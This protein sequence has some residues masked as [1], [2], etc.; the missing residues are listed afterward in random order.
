MRRACNLDSGR[1][2]SDPGRPPRLRAF[3]FS[4]DGLVFE[5]LGHSDPVA[6][7]DYRGSRLFLTTY[8]ERA[9]GGSAVFADFDYV[10][11]ERQGRML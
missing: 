2:A 10:V 8:T 11:G 3:A 4:I 6:M 1:L 9:T 7:S 5:P